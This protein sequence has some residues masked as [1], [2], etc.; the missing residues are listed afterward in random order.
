MDLGER[1]VEI[2]WEAD[3]L[4]TEHSCCI[5]WWGEILENTAGISANKLAK[6]T[7]R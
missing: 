2:Y 1:I 4:K 7:K 3:P 6:I 5:L